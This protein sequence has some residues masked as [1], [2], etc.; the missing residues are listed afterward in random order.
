[1]RESMAIYL[2]YLMIAGYYSKGYQELAF[3]TTEEEQT[4]LL[5]R[6]L[7]LWRGK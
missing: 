1:M 5:I 4:T 2:K 3:D 6:W 7:E